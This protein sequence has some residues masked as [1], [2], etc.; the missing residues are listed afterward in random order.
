MGYNT[1]WP[2]I[3]EKLTE[4]M[5]NANGQS[6]DQILSVIRK[7]LDKGLSWLDSIFLAFLSL[8]NITKM[9]SETTEKTPGFLTY[10]PPK[11]MDNLI[12]GFLKTTKVS[13][14]VAIL[15][16]YG[17]SYLPYFSFVPS[18]S[19]FVSSIYRVGICLCNCNSS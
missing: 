5:R 8:W 7:S 4:I 19:I 18:T 14:S 16:F 1:C 13:F 2:K 12:T 6:H 11:T 3:K 15:A 9:I 17:T 10:N